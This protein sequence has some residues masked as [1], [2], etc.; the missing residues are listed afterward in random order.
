MLRY[1]MMVIAKNFRSKENDT[2]ESNDGI[3]T[4]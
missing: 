1:Q 4:F 3:K 2:L